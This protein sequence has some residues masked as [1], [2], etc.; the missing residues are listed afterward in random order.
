M[1][2]WPHSQ[3]DYSQNTQ[4]L[5]QQQFDPRRLGRNNSGLTE[6]DVSDVICILH[7][8]TPAAFNIVYHTAATNPQ[9]VLER[10]ELAVSPSSDNMSASEME[11]II[12]HSPHVEEGEEA[13]PGKATTQHQALDLAL[14]FSSSVMDPAK[15]FV[16]GR[17]TIR[18]D[19]NLDS[20]NVQKRVSNVHF[21]IYLN[22]NGILMI[23]DSST[24]GTLVDSSLL[25]GRKRQGDQNV[26]RGQRQHHMLNSGSTIEIL[27]DKPSETI[28]FV[29]RI[30]SREGHTDAYRERYQ[31]YMT[32]HVIAQQRAE[33][34]YG[35]AQMPEGAARGVLAAPLAGPPNPKSIP[36]MHPPNIS[37]DFGMH[38]SGGDQFKCTGVLGKGAFATVYQLATRIDGELYAG[39]ELEK[40]RFVKN[41]Q[42]D[43]RLDNEMEIM[44]QIRHDNIVQY[45]GY[46]ETPEHLYIIMEFVP[47]GDMAGYMNSHSTLPEHQ[48]KSMTRQI[49]SALAHLHEK[50][51][52][53]RDIKPDNIL[54][55][56]EDPLV[57]KLTDFGLSKVVKNHETFLKTF[58]GTLL[59]CAPEVFPHYDNYMAGRRQKRRRHATNRS[60]SQLVDIWSYAAVL[61]YVLCGKPPFEGVVDANGKGMFNR[62]METELD[63]TPLEEQGISKACID[64]LL[65]MLNTDPMVRPDEAACLRHPWL[66]EGAS[67]DDED[68]H[69]SGLEMIPEGDEDLDASQLSIH[70]R[71]PEV[72]GSD[73]QGSRE[74][75]D[76]KR[77]M[78]DDHF[79]H[80]RQAPRIPSSEEQS[81]IE[82]P[83]VDE[84]YD[85]RVDLPRQRNGKL[86]GEIS[87]GALKS[88]AL[89]GATQAATE[90]GASASTSSDFDLAA[91]GQYQASQSGYGVKGEAS[92]TNGYQAHQIQSPS[93]AHEQEPPA[94]Y[95]AAGDQPPKSF[96]ESM[97][98]ELNMTS[99]N[100][101]GNHE[102]DRTPQQGQQQSKTPEG[103]QQPQATGGEQDKTPKPNPKPRK[104][105]MDRIINIPLQASVF[106]DPHDPNTHN[107]AYA[108]SISGHKFN[109]DGSLLEMNASL[110]TTEA[111][112][113][114]SSKSDNR[115]QTGMDKENSLS[116]LGITLPA[117]AN[118][119]EFTKPLPVLGRLT[120]TLSSFASINL[121]I[122][123]RVT[124]WGRAF[125]NDFVYRESADT[126]VP[127]VGIAI[128][129][130]APGDAEAS[131]NDGT[132]WMHSKNLETIV[133]TESR[134]GIWVNGVEL[135]SF[136]DKGRRYWG[137]VYTGDEIRIYEKGEERL[138]FTC[139]ISI[140]KG[141]RSRS[142]RDKRFEIQA[143]DSF[144]TKSTST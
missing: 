69:Y 68:Y 7:P 12:I 17:N 113:T 94:G 3:R 86:F 116:A 67:S 85:S 117:P 122:T 72:V 92:H 5:T 130:W 138:V 35:D 127:K 36:G 93:L 2:S 109:P 103:S 60:Y 121:P 44:T 32:H 62:I 16:F 13:G 140:G 112:S 141:K 64:L 125:G 50:N 34:A 129:F 43:Q 56:S 71:H 99:P 48:A 40:R 110:Q 22:H 19:I 102:N 18:C 80:A 84:I 33:A 31:Q 97:V 54:I 49:L 30:P 79:A 70:D 98:R 142:R 91:R 95:Q 4:P 143:S 133:W 144:S 134:S 74:S 126:R 53:H 114:D 87:Q 51:I 1:A 101:S 131:K 6:D 136:D 27:S 52:T 88:S 81:F 118:E 58:C 63:T 137:R 100:A 38:W 9:H 115:A 37:N 29:L 120:T 96:R 47:C 21:R 23:E 39:K 75:R 46:K 123:K 25:G 59:Y 77:Q 90:Q 28:R 26:M 76:H 15:G 111:A 83:L 20:R 124:T 89:L 61:W 104:P 57:V 108:E 65:Q 107:I 10:N 132:S 73:S 82:V 41:G 135:K 14:R 11:T 106:Y 78:P 128:Q 8:A 55:A 45:H 105:R 24:N 66:A 139:E 119:S 42:L